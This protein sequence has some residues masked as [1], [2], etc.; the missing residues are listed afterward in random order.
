MLNPGTPYNVSASGFTSGTGLTYQWEFT[1]NGGGLWQNYGTPTTTYANLIGLIAP[2]LGTVRT[3]R[4]TVFCTNSSQ[5]A[6]STMGTFTSQITYCTPVST[7]TLDY[8]SNFSTT[9]G[10]TNI[11]NMGSGLSGTG[12]GDFYATHSASQVAGG[13][14]NFAENYQGGNHGFNIWVDLNKNGIFES[15][16]RLY[17]GGIT[18]TAFNG[19]ITIP[20]A[21]SPGDYRMR[22]RAWYGNAD[23]D[24]CTSITYGEAED[25]ML[26]VIAMTACSG[27]PVGGAVTVSPTFGNAGSSYDVTASGYTTGTGLTYQWQYSDTGAAG[28]WTTVGVATTSYAALTGQIAPALGTVRTWQLVVTCTASAGTGNST[29]GTFSTVITYCTPSTTGTIDYISSFSTTGGITNI[30]NPS[31]NLS[32]TGY[33]DF[34]AA[35]SASQIAGGSLNFTETYQGGNHGFNI[36]VDLNKN[37]TFEA[38]ERLYIGAGTATTFSGTITIPGTTAPGDYRMRIRAHWN[39][40]NPDPC[41]SINWGE[42][43]DYK[44]TVISATPCTEPTAQPTNLL[45]SVAGTTISGT[46]TA[47]IPAPNSYLV[48]Y[49]TTGTVPT[50]VDG[51]SYTI[52][53]T[54]GAGNIVGDI[55]GNTNFSVSGLTAFTTY[56]FFV[57]AYNNSACLPNYLIS[58]PITNVAT[59]GVSYC[60]PVFTSTVEPITLVQ[61]AGINNPSTNSTGPPAYQDFTGTTPANVIQNDDYT[62]TVKGNTAGG[63]TN[64]FTAFIDWNQDGDFSG[65]DEVYP[66]GSINGSTGIDAQFASTLINVPITALPGA[67]RMRI[68]KNFNSSPTNPCGTYSFGQTEDYTVNVSTPIPPTITSFPPDACGGSSIVITGTYLSFATSVTVGGTAVQAITDNTATSITVTLASGT[69]GAIEV[70]TAGGTATSATNITVTPAPGAPPNL[71]STPLP[72]GPYCNSVVISYVVGST[73]PE[74]FRYWQ[75]VPNGTDTSNSALTYTFNTITVLLMFVTLVLVQHL[76]LIGRHLVQEIAT[77]FILAPQTRLLL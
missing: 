16:E 8:I 48:V 47:A 29:T 54:V 7:S 59:T 38:S 63:F 22:I 61:F 73:P 28:P 53:S 24:P 33:G 27:T 25:Y 3:W 32:G 42:A 46:F 55:D 17:I 67:T 2:A 18:R 1:D 45:L 14:L 74:I 43:E 49:N 68:I 20:G 62:I 12:Y 70:T 31:G 21:T 51:T 19:S 15:S 10:I 50:P 6:V 60:I 58:A 40:A 66:I 11:S 44:L 77:M 69:T 13:I 41:D 35:Y 72:P 26:T 52:G 30:N 34:Y 23:P 57:F 36:W 65:A 37:G 56:H 64:Y 9:G 75:T 71:I 5:T 76:H 4:L 39:S